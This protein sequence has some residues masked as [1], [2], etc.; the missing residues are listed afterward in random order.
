MLKSQ[1]RLHNDKKSN[2]D[3]KGVAR[4]TPTWRL[5]PKNTADHCFNIPS[6]FD[7]P[8][9]IHIHANCDSLKYKKFRII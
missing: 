8:Y 4:R 5:G 3:S 9:S 6:P 2:S 7:P 1:T